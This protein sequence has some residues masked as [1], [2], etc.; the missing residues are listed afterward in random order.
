MEPT[1]EYNVGEWV[2]AE[3]KRIEAE[4][5]RLTTLRTEIDRRLLQLQGQADLIQ[6]MLAD[7]AKQ[8]PPT[9]IEAEPTGD[10]SP[11]KPV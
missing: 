1:T 4:R 6:R 11:V 2:A 7:V 5:A 10:S 3:T 9:G 8:R